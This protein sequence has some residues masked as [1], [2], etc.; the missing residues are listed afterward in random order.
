MAYTGL[1]GKAHTGTGSK[2]KCMLKS[3]L[4]CMIIRI[5]VQMGSLWGV[6]GW[7][8]GGRC[9]RP[10]RSHPQA[11]QRFPAP[12]EPLYLC[13]LKSISTWLSALDVGNDFSLDKYTYF[14][15]AAPS[16]TRIIIIS[17]AN[18]DFNMPFSIG[19]HQARPS[20][21]LALGPRE[22][23]I[24][25]PREGHVVACPMWSI[26]ACL[27]CLFSRS[28]ASLAWLPWW[29]LDTF[30]SQKLRITRT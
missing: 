7:D 28:L 11:A 30:L 2:L 10:P 15:R 8:L 29:I 24:L 5:P 27:M 13:R 12:Q 26:V 21:G 4:A 16:P 14:R 19:P 3:M 22:G 1:Q 9:R 23:P 25:G 6:S 18:I 17:Q 20:Y